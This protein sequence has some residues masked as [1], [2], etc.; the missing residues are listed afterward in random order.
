MA[1]P[2][3]EPAPHRGPRARG[4]ARIDGV[5]IERQ[6]NSLHTVGGKDGD[7]FFDKG[8][9]AALV[10]IV[11]RE[12]GH[13]RISHPLGFLTVDAPQP[14]QD[15][16]ILEG[17]GSDSRN[18]H[19]AG[20]AISQDDGYG[21]SMDIAAGTGLRGVGVGVGVDPQQALTRLHRRHSA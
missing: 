21:H 10:D 15:R 7:G 19:E 8:R 5:G 16:V 4:L 12:V 2:I 17:L 14:Q 18:I 1:L 11:H 3:G 20:G 9:D 13:L 6:V